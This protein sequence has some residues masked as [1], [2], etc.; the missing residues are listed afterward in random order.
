[1][2]ER[3]PYPHERLGW[4][5]FLKRYSREDTSDHGMTEDQVYE[6]ER[7][8]YEKCLEAVGCDFEGDNL[9]DLS[10]VLL[11][12]YEKPHWQPVPR[13]MMDS[14]EAEYIAAEDVAHFNLTI[15]MDDYRR[16]R[17]GLK[18]HRERKAGKK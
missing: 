16:A 9:F 4:E 7:E 3:K 8:L 10:L 15:A 14:T 13:T 12:D 6:F 11:R 1:M 18:F 17:V 5:E 2:S